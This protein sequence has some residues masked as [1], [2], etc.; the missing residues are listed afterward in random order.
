MPNAVTPADPSRRR[1]R[2]Y[3]AGTTAQSENV[4]RKIEGILKFQGLGMRDVVMMHVYLV[5]DPAMGDKMDL[6]G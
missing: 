6:R 3:A 5:G 2:S 4:F 1:P